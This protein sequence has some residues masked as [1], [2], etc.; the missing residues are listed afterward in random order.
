MYFWVKW[1]QLCQGLPIWFCSVI[2]WLSI[3]FVCFL[4]HSPL[5]TGDT[6]VRGLILVIF[7]TP[8]AALVRPSFHTRYTLSLAP[9]PLPHLH[10]LCFFLSHLSSESLRVDMKSIISNVQEPQSTSLLRGKKMTFY[11]PR[12]RHCSVGSLQQ[13]FNTLQMIYSAVDE[14]IVWEADQLKLS[15]WQGVLES[16]DKAHGS[17]IFQ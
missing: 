17:S 14:V 15:I 8:E 13:T 1:H 11:T 16:H 9:L 4:S 2:K 7:K 6:V 5:Y 3:G 10:N 12:H